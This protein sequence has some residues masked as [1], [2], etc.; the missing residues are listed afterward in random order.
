MAR[1]SL[2]RL[3]GK[4]SKRAKPGQRRNRAGKIQNRAKTAE[5]KVNQRFP[6]T[7]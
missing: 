2:S 1:L 5:L 6:V 4:D 7:A 3:G